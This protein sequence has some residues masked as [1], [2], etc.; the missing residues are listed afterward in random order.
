[1]STRCITHIRDGGREGDIICSFYRR[2]DGYPEGHGEA[3]NDWLTEKR[4]VN[5]IRSNSIAG[6]DYNS[7]GS[8]V[9]DLMYSLSYDLMYSL[10]YAASIQVIPS[11]SNADYG[12]EYIYNVYWDDKNGVMCVDV[13]EA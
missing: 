5:G 2:S 3:L 12:Q 4:I 7:I 8:L 1:M 10:S 11:G 9:V 13:T 6:K